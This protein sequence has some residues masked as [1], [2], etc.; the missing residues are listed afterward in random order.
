L[1]FWIC[2]GFRVLNL[3]F[4]GIVADINDRESYSDFEKEISPV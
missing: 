2:L 4:G 3:G 1:G